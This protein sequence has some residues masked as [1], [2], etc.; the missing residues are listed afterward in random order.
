MK[1]KYSNY[2]DWIEVEEQDIKNELVRAIGAVNK[3]TFV[4][5]KQ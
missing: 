4:I 1:K 3:I 2:V 5:G